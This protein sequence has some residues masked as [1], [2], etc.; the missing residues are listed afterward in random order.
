[1][2]HTRMDTIRLCGS[3]ASLAGTLFQ[4]GVIA[5]TIPAVRECSRGLCWRGG[6]PGLIEVYYGWGPY[7]DNQGEGALP[8]KD[9]RCPGRQAAGSP[10]R[11]DHAPLPAGFN[12]HGFPNDIIACVKLRPGGSVTAV[13]LLTGTGKRDLD[14]QVLRSIHRRWR[15]RPVEAG[16]GDPSWQRVRLSAGYRDVPPPEPWADGT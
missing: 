15:F 13:R 8:P 3:A 6:D 5:A 14:R 7:L 12:P 16:A 1:M 4:L 9:R 2:Y 10:F 11:L